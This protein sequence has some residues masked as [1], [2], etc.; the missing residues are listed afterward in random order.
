[1]P[2]EAVGAKALWLP[3]ME[4]GCKWPERVRG[5]P[6]LVCDLM[7]QYKVFGLIPRAV[8]LCCSVLSQQDP[9]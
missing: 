4:K 7:G 3:D 9:V 8:G 2:E 1:M 5:R 6:R